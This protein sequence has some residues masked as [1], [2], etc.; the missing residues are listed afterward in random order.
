MTHDPPPR[1]VTTYTVMFP[2]RMPE[3]NANAMQARRMT[4]GNTLL[5]VFAFVLLLVVVLLKNI[6]A[7]LLC[8]LVG[9][10]GLLKAYVPL[11]SDVLEDSMKDNLAGIDKWIKPCDVSYTGK[12]P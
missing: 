1:L 5:L 4:R 6:L 9:L 3:H 7:P 11:P 12:F 2:S 8:H 10:C